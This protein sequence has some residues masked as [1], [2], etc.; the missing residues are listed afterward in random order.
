MSTVNILKLLVFLNTLKYCK[1]SGSTS[2]ISRNTFIIYLMMMNNRHPHQVSNCIVSYVAYNTLL[3]SSLIDQVFFY[4]L[5]Y[6]YQFIN[7]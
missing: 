3:N 1:H 5:V 4:L 7:L 6:I 2:D